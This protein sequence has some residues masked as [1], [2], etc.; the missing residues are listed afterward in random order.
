MAQKE[1]LLVSF[2]SGSGEV[3]HRTLGA[4]AQTMEGALPEYRV[5]QAFT[6]QAMIDKLYIQSGIKV[7]YITEALDRAVGDGVQRL[8]VQPTQLTQGFDCTRVLS[9]A[10]PYAGQFASLRVGAPLLDTEEDIRTVAGI[11]TKMTEPYCDGETAVC[12]MAHGNRDRPNPV[13]S[14]LEQML[15]GQDRFIAMM[16]GRPN[17]QDLLRRM[18]AKAYRR[19]VLQ[20]LLLTAGGHAVRDMAGDGEQ[21]WKT[22]FTRAGYPV[23]CVMRGLGEFA[24]I[25]SLFTAHAKAAV[26]IGRG[27]CSTSTDIPSPAGKSGPDSPPPDRA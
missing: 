17:V 20:P 22:I 21:A 14:R 12:F 11:L 5:R 18:Q 1:V 15:P 16:H 25:Q 24:P 4:I 9:A 27:G 8:I 23:A 26:E 6:S 13:F 19:V 7:D 3:F 2:G 10:A